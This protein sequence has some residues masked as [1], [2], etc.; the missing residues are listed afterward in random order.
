MQKVGFSTGSHYKL[1]VSA[2][3][4]NASYCLCYNSSLVE[5]AC[6][7]AWELEFFA[8][9]SVRWLTNVGRISLHLPCRNIRYR[10]DKATISAMVL[11]KLIHLR[12]GLT[13]VVIHPDIVDDWNMVFSFD[14]PISIENMD[15]R[16]KSGTT[17]ASLEKIMSRHKCQLV[18][19]LAHCSAFGKDM[20]LAR[21]LIRLFA[22]NLSHIHLSGFDSGH[23]L[24]LYKTQQDFIIEAANGTC[25]PIII[26]SV[27]DNLHEAKLEYE[28]ITERLG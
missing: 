18:L 15:A 2:S 16:K 1:A 3:A 17:A 4:E 20:G 23:H 9:K 13:S 22:D 19:D 27:L 14:L 12:L 11:A 21:E 7:N 6:I 26:E 5:I 24:P 8:K 28:Y 10:D 25:V